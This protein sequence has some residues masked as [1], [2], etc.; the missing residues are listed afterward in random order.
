MCVYTPAVCT[1]T[2]TSMVL[3]ASNVTGMTRISHLRCFFSHQRIKLSSSLQWPIFSHRCHLMVMGLQLAP[4]PSLIWAETQQP[5]G[6][7][8]NV[9]V[10][11]MCG[12]VRAAWRH[13]KATAERIQTVAGHEWSGR[14]EYTSAEYTLCRFR[15]IIGNDRYYGWKKWGQ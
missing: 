5:I 8:V 14:L 12:G 4:V 3:M 10:G 6:E 1:H 13:I 15:H 11:G 2:V 9:H 7:G